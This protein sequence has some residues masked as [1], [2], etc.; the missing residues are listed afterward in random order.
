MINTS[1]NNRDKTRSTRNTI[2]IHGG[3][4]MVWNHSITQ[5]LP[6]RHLLAAAILITGDKR[7]CRICVI[8]IFVEGIR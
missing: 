6:A 5:S 3:P 8:N 7:R 2:G 1:K 4:L